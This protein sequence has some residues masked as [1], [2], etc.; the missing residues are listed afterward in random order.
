MARFRCI[1]CG[2]FPDGFLFEANPGAAA[3]PKCHS[4]GPMFI[5]PIVDVHFVVMDRK[6]PILGAMGRQYV[7]CQRKRDHLA[8]HQYD[9]FAA[10]DDPSAVSCLS[11]RGT[12]E[13]Q[14]AAELDPSIAFRA[15]LQKRLQ[16][17][18]CG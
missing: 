13:W 4:S 6:G 9:N 16:A 17:D 2:Q 7:A 5:T 15:E 8:L 1:N 12:K 11:C 18:C 3:C 10:T 14:E